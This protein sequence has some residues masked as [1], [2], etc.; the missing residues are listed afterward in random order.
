MDGTTYLHQ[1][2]IGGY[3]PFTYPLILTRFDTFAPLDNKIFC[4]ILENF[5]AFLAMSSRMSS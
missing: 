1:S 2:V 5:V 3:Y 4:V